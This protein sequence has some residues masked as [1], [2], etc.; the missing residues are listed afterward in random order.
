[1]HELSIAHSLVET[2]VAEARRHGAARVARVELALGS[3]SGVEPE[4][5]A[6]CFPLAAQGTLCQDAVLDVQRVPAEGRCPA[7]MHQH[8]VEDL[9]SSCPGCGHWPLEVT[10]GREMTLRSLEVT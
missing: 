6:F 1:M 2:A 7:C 8:P 10:G 9:M 4:A 5:L 3:L